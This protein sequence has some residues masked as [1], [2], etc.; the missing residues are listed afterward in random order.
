MAQLPNPL[1]ALKRLKS[2]QRKDFDIVLEKLRELSSHMHPHLIKLLATLHHKGRYYLMYPYADLNLWGYWERTPLPEFS[3]TTLRWAL[4]QCKGIASGLMALHEYR[5][6]YEKN[7]EID[8]DNAYAPPEDSEWWYGRHGDIMPESILWLEQNDEDNPQGLLVL[9][10]FGLLEFHAKFT[11]SRVPP[12]HY[13]GSPTYEPPECRLKNPVTRAID[14]WCLGCVYLEFIT[15]LVLGWDVLFRF[16]DARLQKGGVT[17]EITDDAF[18]TILGERSADS[19]QAIVRENVIEWI[20]DLHEQPRCSKFIH[21][22]LDLIQKNMLIVDPSQRIRCGHLNAILG[23]MLD[24]S[25]IDPSYL[26]KPAPRQPRER[27]EIA[28]EITERLAGRSQ[29]I[30]LVMLLP[31]KGSTLPLRES[32]GVIEGLSTP[33]ASGSSSVSQHENANRENATQQQIAE[34]KFAQKMNDG[35]W[36]SASSAASDKIQ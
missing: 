1:L 3:E 18:Y 20:K 34:Q 12:E 26:T 16:T 2:T 28:K 29:D 30:P 10:Y 31:K 22:V 11:K 21:D 23:E 27:N 36:K 7:T 33:L 4:I 24:K 5:T 17:D 9:N 32:P 6:P 13:I 15:W 8:G 35:A 19:N 14:I 25:I